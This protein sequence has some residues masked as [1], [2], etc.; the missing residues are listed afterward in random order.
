MMGRG[1]GL[2]AALTGGETGDAGRGMG[3]GGD[4]GLGDGFRPRN[5]SFSVRGESPL[6]AYH[7][8]GL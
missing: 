7:S 6:Q 5:R 3:I 2:E 1:R 8:L 4:G